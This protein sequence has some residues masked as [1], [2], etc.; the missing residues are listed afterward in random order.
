MITKILELRDRNTFIPVIAVGMSAGSEAQRY[1]L[2]R[3]GYVSD[4][5][6]QPPVVLL[7][8]A[9]GGPSRYDCYDWDD[10]TF[11]VAHEYVEK[12]FP[13]LNDGDVVDV[14]Y[15]LGETQT[16]KVSEREDARRA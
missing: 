15:I 1:L 11:R 5:G 3:A 10:R 16:P 13:F 2:R 6:S 12:H 8:R 4:P 9:Q 14:E 7:V